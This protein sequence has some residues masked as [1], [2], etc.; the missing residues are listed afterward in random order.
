MTG[1]HLESSQFVLRDSPVQLAVGSVFHEGIGWISVKGALALVIQR[2]AAQRADF[3]CG[4][5][6]YRAIWDSGVHLSKLRFVQYTVRR[7]RETQF[8]LGH[9]VGVGASRILVA[10]LF[11]AAILGAEVAESDV[12]CVLSHAVQIVSQFFQPPNKTLERTALAHRF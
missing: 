6:G 11:L 7:N 2:D 1:W 5:I 3:R 12:I 9:V 10:H 4:I 8:S